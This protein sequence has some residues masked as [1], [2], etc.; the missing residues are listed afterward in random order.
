MSIIV[1]KTAGNS[2]YIVTY[3]Q[4]MQADIVK[5]KRKEKKKVKK[6]K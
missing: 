6:T 3:P 4:K 5:K 1:R 2:V